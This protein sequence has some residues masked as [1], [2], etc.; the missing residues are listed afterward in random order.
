MVRKRTPETVVTD[1]KSESLFS[2][3]FPLCLIFHLIRPVTR[4]VCCLCLFLTA[5]SQLRQRT[6]HKRTMLL[7]E[8]RILHADAH[9]K[10]YSVEVSSPPTPHSTIFAA[11]R[12]PVDYLLVG[13]TRKSWNNYLVSIVSVLMCQISGF[14]QT[15]PVSLGEFTVI[16]C[17]PAPPPFPRA[18]P[19]PLHRHHCHHHPTTLLRA[20][21][22]WRNGR[23]FRVEARRRRVRAVLV[24]GGADTL[25]GVRQAGVHRQPQQRAELS[26]H[27]GCG[28]AY[29]VSRRP[30]GAGQGSGE[31]VTGYAVLGAEGDFG[32]AV[33]RSEHRANVGNNRN[34]HN[35]ELFPWTEK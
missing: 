7:L 10:C 29:L 33:G 11:S 19:G 25:S 31:S 30:G 14:A 27:H 8:Q 34:Q 17:P 20:D 1:Y 24:V 3:T 26:A 28:R 5:T 6:G 12:K 16:A 18:C 13:L 2:R 9:R 21:R 35:E 32:G 15:V 4:S 23:V 22:S